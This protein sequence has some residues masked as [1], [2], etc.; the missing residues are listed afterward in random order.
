MNILINYTKY[1]GRAWIRIPT[2]FMDL[3]TVKFNEPMG[4]TRILFYLNKEDGNCWS[5]WNFKIQR[6]RW[7][8]KSSIN[9]QITYKSTKDMS[10][11]FFLE[12]GNPVWTGALGGRA[13]KQKLFQEIEMSLISLIFHCGTPWMVKNCRS[14][15]LFF[16]LYLRLNLWVM[17]NVTIISRS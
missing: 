2:K 16:G 5:C 6:T 7:G 15:F 3:K 12:K 4:L 9:S 13:S 17:N 1:D 14:F 10:F 11:F 8:W